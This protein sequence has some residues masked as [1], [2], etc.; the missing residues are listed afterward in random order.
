M[1]RV[2]PP[3]GGPAGGG[4]CPQAGGPGGEPN[5]GGEARRRGGPVGGPARTTRTQHP[6]DGLCGPVE[7]EGRMGRWRPGAGDGWEEAN[8]GVRAAAAAHRRARPNRWSSNR[9][10][11]E[12][13]TRGGPMRTRSGGGPVKRR[14]ACGG[15][16]LN[17][18]GKKGGLE[19]TAERREKRG[20]WPRR[21]GGRM[22]TAAATRTRWSK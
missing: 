20:R 15:A 12:Q 4:G 19:E 14:R 2:D 9:A 16:I 13:V 11:M 8:A 5:G 21:G 3:G 1:R 6:G 17:P 18:M 7:P 22:H 10:G